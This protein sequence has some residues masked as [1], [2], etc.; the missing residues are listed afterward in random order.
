MN[1][2]EQLQTEDWKAKRNIILERDNHKCVVC[3]RKRPKIVGLNKRF[4]IL[5]IK[6]LRKNGVIIS[7]DNENQIVTYI[8]D[9]WIG[10]SKFI[11]NDPEKFVLEDLKFAQQTTDNV[12]EHICFTEDIRDED[13]LPDLNIHHKYYIK[14]NYAWEYEDNALTTLCVDCHQKEHQDN[15]IVVYSKFREKL[16]ETSVCDKCNGSGYLKEYHYY[17]NGVCFECNGHGIILR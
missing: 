1:Y 5:D 11:E 12:T 13:I 17:A 2:Q 14:D 7:V 16:Y 10:I 15:V 9:S 3:S 6:E 4:G 8:Y